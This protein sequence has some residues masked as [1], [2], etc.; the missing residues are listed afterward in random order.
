MR[1][2]IRDQKRLE[3][4][5]NAS[6]RREYVRRMSLEKRNRPRQPDTIVH[7]LF[8][9]PTFVNPAKSRLAK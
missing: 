5:Y 3:M 2:V 8:E 9:I 4:S 7:I 1:R 6:K